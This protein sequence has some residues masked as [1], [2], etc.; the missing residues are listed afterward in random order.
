MFRK[1]TS[2]IMI[3]C[4]FIIT[5]LANA[6]IAF[7]DGGT[8]AG[9]QAGTPGLKGQKPLSYLG[10]FLDGVK[11]DNATDVPVDPRLQVDFDKNVVNS[12][13]WTNNSQCFTLK[14]VNNEIIPIRVTKID[15][16]VDPT[17][18]QY[19]FVHPASPL[20][21]GTSYQLIISPNL[22]AKNG[23]SLG[24]GGVTVAFKTL[25]EAIQQAETA[26]TPPAAQPASQPATQ[27]A[28]Q[29][30]A[31]AAAS[32]SSSNPNTE[33]RADGK[34]TS[35]NTVNLSS[36]AEQ[37]KPNDS[38]D[39]QKR[40]K[41]SGTTTPDNTTITKPKTIGQATPSSISQ[42]SNE[43]GSGISTTTWITIIGSVLLAAW[44][45]IEI[46]LRK[47]RNK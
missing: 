15:D 24:D 36:T 37:T 19:I 26:N 20:T 27:P 9:A 43:K 21:Q 35:P 10:T 33:N 6:S 22:L 14:S 4:L 47:K 17:Q 16:T 2:I 44:I 32:T 13:I 30:A 11:I 1:K 23:L 7:A 12:L 28:T 34:T 5:C 8:A 38:S 40:S 46:I 31:T 25:G 18:R 45:A 3:I 39:I 42:S 41:E 29:P